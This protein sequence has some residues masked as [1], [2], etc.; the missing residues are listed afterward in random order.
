MEH[1]FHQQLLGL[2][3]SMDGIEQGMLHWVIVSKSHQGK[4][5]CHPLVIK[6][7]Q[8]LQQNYSSAFLTTQPYSFKGI[9]IYLDMGFV[10]VEERTE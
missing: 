2:S 6:A 3:N 10:P 4:G 9:K 1:P 7:I 8:Q 5:L